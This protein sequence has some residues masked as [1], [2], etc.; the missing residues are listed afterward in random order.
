MKGISYDIVPIDLVAG[1]QRSDEYRS[2]NPGMAVPTLMLDDGT[3]LTQSLT[4]L[5]YLD[6]V[7]AP[8]LTP[9]E[10]RQRA[11]VLAAAHTIALDIHPVNN[12]RV[13]QKLK[14]DYGDDSQGWMQHWMVEGF[15]AI[16]S[17][18][19][20]RTTFAFS[21]QPDLADICITAQVYNA[22]RWGLDMN[23]FPK[24]NRVERACLAL[25]AIANAHPDKQ[26]DAGTRS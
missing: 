2:I 12:L 8:T 10:T 11:R 6:S 1:E 22:K 25:P 26:E 19:D 24:I 13:V 5:D 7:A 20:D 16:E 21:S 3:T 4:I 9:T 18:L 15:T 23:P 17:M 14:D